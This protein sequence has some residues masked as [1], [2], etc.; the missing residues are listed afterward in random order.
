MNEQDGNNEMNECIYKNIDPAGDPFIKRCENDGLGDTPL[1]FDVPS[2]GRAV[3]TKKPMEIL[4][5]VVVVQ[6]VQA[7]VVLALY[8]LSLSIMD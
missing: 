7:V 8:Y 4:A 1:P 2:F 6:V 3:G 5:V